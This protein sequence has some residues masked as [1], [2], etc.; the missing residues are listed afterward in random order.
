MYSKTTENIIISVTPRYED[1]PS[2]PSRLH[3]VFSYNIII[4]NGGNQIVQLKRRFWKIKSADGLIREVEGEGVVGEQPILHPGDQFQYS[5][6]AP[7]TCE[8]GE[9]S[10]YFLMKNMETKELF[11]VL[12]PKF[13]FVADPLLN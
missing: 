9:M 7:I 11:K 1:L 3:F 6:W 4:E 8:I 2:D 13:Q 10:G 12:V 5:S